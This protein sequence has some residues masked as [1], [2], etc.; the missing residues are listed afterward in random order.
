MTLL[1]A[2]DGGA[3][4]DIRILASDI[5]TD[6]L[7]RA[8]E[9][10][11]ALDQLAPVPV[12][13]V[14]RHFLRGRGE[15]E[16]TARIRPAVRNLVTFRRINFLDDPWPIRASFDAIFCRNVLIYFD[17]STQRRVLERFV[18]LLKDEGLLFLGHSESAYGLLDGVALVGNTVYRRT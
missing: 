5:D 2:L 6:V 11:Y 13:L 9:G 16:G 4:W 10:V 1:E 17:R 18:R 15:Y 8:G 12:P 7:A 3:G 14:P